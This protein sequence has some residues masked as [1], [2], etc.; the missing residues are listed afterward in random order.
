MQSTA[1]SNIFFG[2]L[3]LHR[4]Y[5][6][7]PWWWINVCGTIKAKIPFTRMKRNQNVKRS[8]VAFCC[9]C[10]D[11]NEFVSMMLSSF[12]FSCSSSF[13][14][15][16]KLNLCRL[17]SIFFMSFSFLFIVMTRN[18]FASDFISCCC[19]QMKTSFSNNRKT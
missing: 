14:N 5:L 16:F 2:C 3:N 7:L 10:C 8:F 15:I 11:F 12:N 9:C 18:I 13:Y 4:I 19:V 17:D 1:L 6:Y